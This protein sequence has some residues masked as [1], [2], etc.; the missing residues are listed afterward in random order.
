[1][2]SKIPPKIPRVIRKVKNQ[3]RHPRIKI[4]SQKKLRILKK[5]QRLKKLQLK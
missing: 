1:L 2:L 3:K 5:I 4:N